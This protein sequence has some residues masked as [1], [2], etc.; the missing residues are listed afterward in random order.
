MAI[1]TLTPQRPSSTS[2]ISNS[3]N[4]MMGTENQYGSMPSYKTGGGGSRAI[5]GLSKMMGGSIPNPYEFAR[6]KSSGLASGEQPYKQQLM[7]Q[8]YG[9]KGG[10]MKDEYGL[11]DLS[12]FKE[13]GLKG[14]LMEQEY[15]L[16]SKEQSS[17]SGYSSPVAMA[18]RAKLDRERRNKIEDINYRSLNI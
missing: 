2:S 16:K 10:L 4:A 11:K 9:L 18:Q 13:Y 17:L 6:M 3:Y 12:T 14:G 1:K 7:E 15:G 5:E 8:E